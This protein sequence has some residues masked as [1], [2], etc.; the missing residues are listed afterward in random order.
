MSFFI[1]LNL[2]LV[3]LSQPQRWFFVVVYGYHSGCCLG[4]EG[5]RGSSRNPPMILPQVLASW[6]PGWLERGSNCGIKNKTT[7][8]D[9][10]LYMAASTLHL[11]CITT[12]AGRRSCSGMG[13]LPRVLLMTGLGLI[14]LGLT[15]PV[16]NYLIAHPWAVLVLVGVCLCAAGG[17]LAVL[18]DGFAA[19]LPPSLQQCLYESPFEI[20]LHMRTALRN[21]KLPL[22][23]QRQGDA[24][25]SQL[26]R[27]GA[28]CCLDLEAE[29][30]EAVVASLE[31][32]FREAAFQP[33]ARSLGPTLQLLVL[34]REGVSKLGEMERARSSEVQ[35]QRSGSLSPSEMSAASLH[36]RRTT[37]TI[38]R[39]INH[40]RKSEGSSSSGHAG[41]RRSEQVGVQEADKPKSRVRSEPSQTRRDLSL[42]WQILCGHFML[43][44]FRRAETRLRA[45]TAWRSLAWMYNLLL[46]SWIGTVLAALWGYLKWI[47][48]K[49]HQGA[50]RR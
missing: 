12:T 49:V 14:T 6:L 15:S 24:R 50:A 34:G 16:I 46:R 35:L 18:E 39:E 19:L 25:V 32:D 13:V 20:G 7:K 29:L 42:I 28:L 33:C 3:S 48:S 21:L 45:S 27:V 17:T 2:L 8:Q 22:G 1:F 31:D 43:P 47:T 9:V 44:M 5:R 26:A 37:K 4:R 10:V 36:K 23:S 38:A 41:I 40:I 30:V 11:S